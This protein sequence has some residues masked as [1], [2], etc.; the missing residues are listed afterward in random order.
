MSTYSFFYA[1]AYTAVFLVAFYEA[2]RRRLKRSVVV[3]L[4]VVGL[5]GGHF[6]ARFLYLLLWEK[7]S[8]VSFWRTFFDFSHAGTCSSGAVLGVILSVAIF[9]YITK[10]KVMPYLDV[11]ATGAGLCIFFGRIGCHFA[12]CCY[13]VATNVRW[14]ILQHG[15]LRHPTQLYDAANGL[16]LFFAMQKLKTKRVA[17]GFLFFAYLAMYSFIRFFIEFVREEPRLMSLTYSQYIYGTICI[18]SVLIIL[19]KRLYRSVEHRPKKQRK[20][21]K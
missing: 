17:I 20:G 12:G 9:A 3:W 7:H 2:K 6:G 14:A 10:T 15:V 4:A 1:I 5:L 11:Y 21:R 13:G 16:F 19:Y 18:C 8:F